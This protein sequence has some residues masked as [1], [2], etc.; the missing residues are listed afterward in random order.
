M[1]RILTHLGFFCVAL[2]SVATGAPT[3]PAPELLAI[4]QERVGVIAKASAA[5]VAIFESSGQGGGSGVLISPDGFALTNFHVVAPCGAAMKCGLND[6]QLYDAVVVGVD[7]V[8]DVALIQLLGREDFPVAE[9]GDSDQVKV[10]DWAFTAGNPFL[11]ADKFHPSISWGMISGVHRYQYPAGTLLEYADCLQ[12]DAA[13][14][15]GNSGGAL[16][17]AEGRLIGINGRGS[18]EK[19][20]RVN[21]G[22][23]YAIS[24]NQIKRF[25]THLKSG[26]IVDHASLGFTVSTE[27]L[28]RVVVD[29]ILEDCDAYRRGLRYNDQIVRFAGR[30]IRTANALKTALGTYPRDWIV[31]LVFRRDGKTYSVQLRLPGLHDPAQLVDLI[32]QQAEQPSEPPE[33]KPPKPD[34]NEDESPLPNIRDLMPDKPDLPLAVQSRYEEVRGYANYWYNQQRQKQLWESYLGKNALEKM[35]TNWQLAG[36]LPDD[37]RFEIRL[38]G[39]QGEMRMPTGKTGALFTGGFDSQLSPPG[40]GGLLLAVHLWQRM[41]DKGLQQFGEVYYLGQL[42]SGPEGE[43]L[44]CLVGIHGG[45]EIRFMFLPDDGDLVGL[46]LI[47]ADDSDPCEIRFADFSEFSGRRLPARWQVKY[48]DKIFAELSVDSW[49]TDGDHPLQE[50]GTN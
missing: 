47:P 27:E 36:A 12:T 44:D 8:G 37:D 21:V 15:P 9:L 48:G 46:E 39:T 5:T 33:G 6:G 20:G 16:F 24:I 1:I 17:D 3:N 18:F 50:G 19:R 4:E 42:P 35:G 23:G 45:V 11:L 34:E 49:Q 38:T 32:Q 41:I 31:P 13:I 14:N 10:G 26:R 7:P 2:Q 43:L 29:D 22:V 30:E 28:G 40:S 25:V